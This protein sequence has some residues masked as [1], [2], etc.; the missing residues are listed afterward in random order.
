MIGST[1]RERWL[2][3]ARPRPHADIRLFCFP[4]A[5]GGASVFRGWADG[6]PGSVE[7]C[8]VQLPGRETRFREPAFTRLPPLIEALAE[9]LR[10]HLDRPFAFF[11]HSLG[12]LVAF[13]LARY[14]RQ[15]Q[16]REP[17]QLFVSGCGGPQ[18]RGQAGSFIHTLP[19]AEF[20]QEVRR[21][22]GSPAAVLDNEEL[23]ELLLPT[24]RA[25]FALCETYTY[26]A[27]P[28]L[29]CPVCA[30]GGL[31]DDTVDRQDLDAWRELTTG[32]F[33][34]RMLPGDHFFLQTAQPL[35]LQG[36]AQELLGARSPAAPRPPEPPV[37]WPTTPAP[38]RLKEGDVHVWRLPLDQS[39]ES[40]TYLRSLLSADE[41]E[42]ER[43]L[44]FPRDRERFVVCRG[45]LRVL[46]G[47]YLSRQPGRLHFAYG[48]HGKPVLADGAAVGGLRFNVA[49]SEG[50]ALVAVARGRE[51]GV[52]LERVRP[53]MTT[54]QMAASC[55]SPRELEALRA[56]PRPLRAEAFFRCWTRKEAYLKAT[57]T[58]L[59]LGLDRFDVTLRPGE[60][61]AL[62]ANRDD[63]DEV[64]RWSLSDLQ[65]GPGFVGALAVERDS[66]TP[67]HGDWPDRAAVPGLPSGAAWCGEGG[68][69][70]PAPLG[71][72]RDVP[73]GGEDWP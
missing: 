52:D 8:P 30:L 7:V 22:N 72:L 23:T 19:A 5:G 31:G 6:L 12:A 67:W 35:L 26:A 16:G 59:S 32:A 14:L 66:R 36:L 10:P 29:T 69:W 4:Y 24:L 63:P 57:G 61:A 41:E 38:P 68:R 65:P 13:E 53:E 28:P 1:V 11:G 18:A 25:D 40:S 33:R 70:P 56:L 51:V 27:G 9:S 46:L 2:A 58:G 21:L 50:L 64:R 20:W 55:F 43:R 44:R 54:E 49:H 37:A 45:L 60:P 15:H 47:R 42:R 62:L 71:T 48:A 39:A 17:F 34:L 73:R 3:C